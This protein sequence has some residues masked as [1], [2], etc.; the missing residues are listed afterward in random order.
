VYVYG[1]RRYRRAN[2]ERKRLL[3]CIIEDAT[4]IKLPAEGITK[5]HL[6][7]KGGKTETLTT[8]NPTSSAQQVKTPPMII[9]LVDKLLEEHI[10]FEIA[11]ILD[12]QGFRIP[13]N[14]LAFCMA[15]RL[16]MFLQVTVQRAQSHAMNTAELT[17]P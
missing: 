14:T 17:T 6:R 2:R 1:R 13:A 9:Q 8:L 11:D 12:Q 7:F 5:V 15:L 3:V 4:L 10:Y 16:R